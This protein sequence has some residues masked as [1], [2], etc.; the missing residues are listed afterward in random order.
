MNPASRHPVIVPLAILTKVLY[1]RAKSPHPDAQFS[2]PGQEIG[3]WPG[4]E[5]NRDSLLERDDPTSVQ[6][7]IYAVHQQCVTSANGGENS[8]AGTFFSEG[9]N[10][11]DVNV[12]PRTCQ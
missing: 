3:D 8:T 10:R 12:P 2:R 1:W 4:A 9:L 7:R 5:G 6:W 11:P